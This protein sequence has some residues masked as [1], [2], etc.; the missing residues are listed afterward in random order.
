MY[1]RVVHIR[2]RIK[3]ILVPIVVSI[4]VIFPI[5]ILDIDNSTVYRIAAII[6]ILSVI[7][8]PSMYFLQRRD[9]EKMMLVKEERERKR[10]SNN[11]CRELQDT[12][13]G[14]DRNK[15]YNRAIDF[16]TKHGQKVF[17]MN[18]L[19]NHG[20]YDSLIFSGKINFLEP[21]LQQSV[22]NIFRIIKMHN[23][24]LKL[25]EKMSQEKQETFPEETYKYYIWMDEQEKQLLKHI[26]IMIEKLESKFM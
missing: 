24:Y 2:F 3:I 23:E 19:F 21:D 10:A 4:L 6:T 12:L 13:E 15:H 18:R 5:T 20:F 22:Q 16:E 14:L 8:S 7:I 26:P 25:T 1:K 17:F 11:I 9:S